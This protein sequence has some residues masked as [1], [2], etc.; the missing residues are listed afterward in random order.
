MKRFGLLGND[1]ID[2]DRSSVSINNVLEPEEKIGCLTN[3][4]A[5]IKLLE[6]SRPSFFESRPLPIHIKPLVVDEIKR[7]IKEDIIEAVPP[8]GSEWASPIV[9]VTKLN[10]RIRVV[11]DFKVGVNYKICNDYFPMPEIETMFSVIAGC[12]VFAFDMLSI[13]K[14]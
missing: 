9:V 2:V 7:M 10:G 3:F 12:S 8:G 4:E 5:R 13:C 6:G 1:V 11:G 14:I